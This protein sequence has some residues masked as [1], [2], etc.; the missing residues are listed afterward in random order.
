MLL[1]P[2]S[3]GCSKSEVLEAEVHELTAEERSKKRL[4]DVFALLVKKIGTLDREHIF[5]YLRAN[6]SLVWEN[7][8]LITRISLPDKMQIDITLGRIQVID[9]GEPL[10][11]IALYDSGLVFLFED[12]TSYALQSVIL[13]E[14]LLEVF[15]DYVTTS[16]K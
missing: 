2:G 3:T 4:D 13:D 16:S 9:K 15:S 6:T 8:R 10:C 5:S 1:I 11:R 14:S 12:G 7:R